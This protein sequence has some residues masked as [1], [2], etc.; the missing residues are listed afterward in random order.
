MQIVRIQVGSTEQ[1][2]AEIIGAKA[3]N[4]TRVAALGL[5][6]PPAFVL[7]VELCNAIVKGDA[8]ARKELSDG[9]ADGIQFLEQVTSKRF[10]DR[11]RPLCISSIRRRSIDAR[12]VGY[13]SQR[14]LHAGCSSRS[15]KIH[16]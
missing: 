2:S 3:A 13:N 7:P 4:L 8:N 9:L 16:G 5:P 15:Y 10:G 11:R 14:R 12:D 1:P 6:V